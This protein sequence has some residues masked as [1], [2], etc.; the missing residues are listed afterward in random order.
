MK[1]SYFYER[2]IFSNRGW[3]PAM[4]NKLK[5]KMFD[6]FRASYPLFAEYSSHNQSE[7][8]ELL[9]GCQHL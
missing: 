2:I 5:K 9:G 1:G 3:S 6:I 7:Y 4:L 8:R